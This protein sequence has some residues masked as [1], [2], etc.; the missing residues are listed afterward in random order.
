MQMLAKDGYVALKREAEDRWRWSR[1]MSCQKPAVQQTL[2]QEDED[3]DEDEMPEE[4]LGQA[5]S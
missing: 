1:R 5:P 3:E 4:H 2:E